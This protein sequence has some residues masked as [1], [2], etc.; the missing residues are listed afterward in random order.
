[1]RS[2]RT[3]RGETG[4][5]LLLLDA[6]AYRLSTA[7][8]LLFLGRTGASVFFCAGVPFHTLETAKN[9]NA[10]HATVKHVEGEKMEC[11]ASMLKR[12]ILGRLQEKA[13]CEY[14]LM[15]IQQLAAGVANVMN[16]SCMIY[17]R[18]YC[19][20]LCLLKCFTPLVYVRNLLILR[21]AGDVKSTVGGESP[22]IPVSEQRLSSGCLLLTSI[23]MIYS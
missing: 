3:V 12:R 14:P 6:S 22:G 1:M 19:M 16:I 11:C 21:V 20:G 15:I 4:S 7:T 18:S 9:E 2:D 8:L 10:T 13:A 5:P 17:K 23:T